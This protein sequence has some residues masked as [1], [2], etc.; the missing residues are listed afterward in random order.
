ME[1]E[2]GAAPS[3]SSTVGAKS[4]V[5]WLWR[6]SAPL[7]GAVIAGV[8]AGVISAGLGSRIVMRIIALMDSDHHG[9]N[10][11]ASATVG[12]FT[13]GG[14]MSLII[15][16]AVAGV[17]GGL[18][19]LGL[20]RWLWVPPAWRGLAFGGF[21]MVTVGHLLIDGAN[22]DFQIF[23]PILVIVTLFLALFIINGLI[24]APLADRIHPEPAYSR[25]LRVERA[26]AG[27]IAIVSVLGLIGMV[28]TARQ[29]V[30]ERGT[31]FSARGEGNGCAV[32]QS[33]VDRS[34]IR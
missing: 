24:L 5:R 9:V 13:F 12:D 34:N 20:R 16:G 27:I 11:D 15:L 14:T 30:D 26:A 29:M 3:S 8:I 25:Q 31:C 17:L 7:R 33:E 6:G 18:A 1:Q 21:T 22:V 2:V 4:L 23:E 32:L 28:D 19:Y 10:T